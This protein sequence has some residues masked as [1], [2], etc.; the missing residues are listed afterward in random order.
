MVLSFLVVFLVLFFAGKTFN[1][2]AYAVLPLVMIIEYFMALGMTLI[3]CGV[4]VYWRD[5]EY[6]MGIIS[7]AW[8]FATPVMYGIDQI[9]EELVP[10]FNLNPMTHVIVA[11]RDILYYGKVPEMQTLLNA[12]IFGIA[13]LIIGELLFGRLQRHFAEEL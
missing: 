9:P 5:V 1:P 10:F 8:Q 4:T 2:V 3:I 13:T 6:I 12:L 7:M 11:Y